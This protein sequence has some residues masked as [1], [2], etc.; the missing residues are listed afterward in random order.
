MKDICMKM[1]ADQQIK[2]DLGMENQKEII[3]KEIN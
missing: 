2:I 3:F 1:I